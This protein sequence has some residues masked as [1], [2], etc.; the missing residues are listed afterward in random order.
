[1][2]RRDFLIR[3]GLAL[4][5]AT[6]VARPTLARTLHSEEW[7]P[8]DWAWVRSQ[9][10][11]MDPKVANFGGFYLVSHPKT[12]RAAIEKHRA[13]LDHN[14]LEYHHNGWELEDAVRETAGE[15]LGV[16]GKNEIA[17]TDSTTQGLAALYSG[18]K[19]A[20]GQEILT[21]IHDHPAATH[22][23]LALKA[24]RDGTKVER[25]PL[26]AKSS[27]ASVDEMVG[28]VER[29]ITPRTRVLALTWVHSNTGVKTPIRAISEVVTKANA[30]R[31]P[32]DRL[33]F[34]VDGVHGLGI[35]NV[36]LPELGCDFLAAGTHKWIFSP[37][38]TGILWGKAEAWK[39]VVPVIP[40]FGNNQRPGIQ[41]SPGGFHSFE[42]RW[43]QDE[44]FKLH[45][46]IGRSR[47]EAR[48]HELNR[49]IREGLSKMKHVE[50]HTPMSDAL[51]AGI[52]CFDIKGK[53]PDEVIKHL[54][55]RGI[56]GSQSPYTPSCARL[57]ASVWNTEE[58]VERA[59]TAVGDMA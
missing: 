36:T 50:L 32:E 52:V 44:G 22:K 21:S 14:P 30:D 28:N 49:A 1:M 39:H 2:E 27:A 31:S 11:L 8:H 7:Q 20:P 47:V 4:G 38:G 24:A 41:F 55:S 34:C 42:H 16:D 26:Y 46:T 35:D 54:A 18:I 51:S 12:V 37:R 3:G 40:A 19:I 58:E 17:L 43:A 6:V 13:G 15:F 9:F 45:L 59:V 56:M 10:D 57:A 23:T 25:I 33:L 5:A 29:A 48:I 53:K